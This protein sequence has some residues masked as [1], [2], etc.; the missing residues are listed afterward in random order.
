[1]KLPPSHEATARQDGAVSRNLKN[2]LKLE[3]KFTGRFAQGAKIAKM[4]LLSNRIETNDSIN[5][6][7]EHSGPQTK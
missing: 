5:R 1:M 7:L 4:Y 6:I 2:L 3:K